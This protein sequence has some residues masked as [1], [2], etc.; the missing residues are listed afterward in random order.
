MTQRDEIF[1]T[2]QALTTAREPY[3]CTPSGLQHFNTNNIDLSN[4]EQLLMASALCL[5]KAN[6]FTEQLVRAPFFYGTGL[7]LNKVASSLERFES[8]FALTTTYRVNWGASRNWSRNDRDPLYVTLEILQR[9]SSE[10]QRGVANNNRLEYELSSDQIRVLQSILQS[11]IERPKG[12][13]DTDNYYVSYT[14]IGEITDALRFETRRDAY[15]YSFN[16]GYS[17]PYSKIAGYR[18]DTHS[19]K[20][21]LELPAQE[22]S[23]T[24][25]GAFVDA[26]FQLHMFEPEDIAADDEET[27]NRVRLFRRHQPEEV[28]RNWLP[29]P[30]TLSLAFDNPDGMSLY[31]RTDLE[32]DIKP[33]RKLEDMIAGDMLNVPINIEMFDTLTSTSHK[34]GPGVYQFLYN[35]EGTY[36]RGNMFDYSV[37]TTDELI[38]YRVTF[39][40]GKVTAI[41][42]SSKEQVVTRANIS[43]RELSLPEDAAIN[44]SH[45]I[46]KNF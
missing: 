41:T 36:F 26:Y 38:R 39:P 33:V 31:K 9:L 45:Q 28:Y 4:P 46:N 5:A 42:P 27:L 18:E 11:V 8:H 40:T 37:A 44:H 13:Q 20:M 29:K 25:T 6:P 34:L 14:L 19:V 17:F 35:R 43:R 16:Y 12:A 22:V 21:R 7:Y 15:H 24:E 10:L 1:E 3:V 30:E 32:P 23:I 2:L